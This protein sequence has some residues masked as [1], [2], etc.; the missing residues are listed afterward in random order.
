MK[1]LLLATALIEAGAGLAL[2]TCSSGF[3]QLLL[4]LPLE[5]AVGTAVARVGG[6]GLLTLSVAAWF[7]SQDSQSHAAR[8]LVTAMVLYNLGAALILCMTGLT[9]HSVG[10]LLW[11]IVI[12]HAGMACWCVALLLFYPAQIG[13]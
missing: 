11:P 4:A 10:V 5:G 7:A 8:G 6:L 13:H 9:L 12:L 3:T 1:R 2:L